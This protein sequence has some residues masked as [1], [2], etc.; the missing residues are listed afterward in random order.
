[1]TTADDDRTLRT[2]VEAARAARVTVRQLGHWADRGY[3][4]PVHVAGQGY[5]GR[6]LRW[7][8]ADVDRAEMLGVVS[9]TLIQPDVLARFAAALED[10][11]TL[12]FTDGDYDVVVRLSAHVPRRRRGGEMRHV[13]HYGG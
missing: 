10:G 13:A 6:A 2:T 4:Q 8:P 11:P 7:S 1:M 12:L 9:R 5:A 3:L